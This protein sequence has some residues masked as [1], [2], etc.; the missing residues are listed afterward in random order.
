MP[1][2][3]AL[4][5]SLLVTVASN[6]SGKV[7]KKAPPSPVRIEL[8]TEV[9]RGAPQAGADTHVT[10]DGKVYG[11]GR[12]DHRPAVQ[13]CELVLDDATRTGLRDQTLTLLPYFGVQKP[14]LT[15]GAF[16]DAGPDAR[17]QL[18]P[19]S[20]A[21]YLERPE[22]QRRELDTLLEPR[23]RALG[24]VIVWLDA[25][26]WYVD[27][28]YYR[29]T[30]FDPVR[31]PRGVCDDVLEGS[32]EEFLRDS[33]LVAPR[34]T[35]GATALRH[36]AFPYPKDPDV[37]VLELQLSPGMPGTWDYSLTVMADGSYNFT[38]SRSAAQSTFEPHRLTA[39]FKK[40]RAA[41]LNRPDFTGGPHAA[42]R[43]VDD[44]QTTTLR[45]RLDDAQT[46]YT[47]DASTP[48]QVLDFVAAV[49]RA[50]GIGDGP[51]SG[52]PPR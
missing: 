11:M 27:R 8:Y 32:L 13:R 29:F 18:L 37:P 35:E 12:A 44:G 14:D 17:R 10:P 22:E 43:H 33:P 34:R 4:Q 51:P 15:L 16:M 7:A 6:T 30:S 46:S 3:F 41:G 20:L 52:A 50:Y 39:L 28:M 42:P 2:A 26:R 19:P 45:L 1:L 40:A 36:P 31:L 21:T 24:V 49:K 5:L 38:G 47:I 9:E 48:P 23:A 25:R